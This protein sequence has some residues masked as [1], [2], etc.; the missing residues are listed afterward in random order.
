MTIFISAETRVFRKYCTDTSNFVV[1]RTHDP[2]KRNKQNAFPS[3]F[4]CRFVGEYF[5]S[6]KWN[7]P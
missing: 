5:K 6:I 2:V 3:C 7:A 1:E 4:Y